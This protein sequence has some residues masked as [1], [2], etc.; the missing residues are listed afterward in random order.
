MKTLNVPLPKIS[1]STISS[2]NSHSKPA[3]VDI[4]SVKNTDASIKSKSWIFIKPE[5]PK[6]SIIN[7]QIIPPPPKGPAPSLLI[8]NGQVIPPPPNGPAPRPPLLLVNGQVIPPPPSEP[9]PLLE[10]SFGFNGDI[11]P[12]SEP[13]Q[14]ALNPDKV[15]YNPLFDNK[16]KNILVKELK[17]EHNWKKVRFYDN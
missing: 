12:S 9:A 16:A 10:A 3:S 2:R 1:L 4:I 5:N 8:V 6:V 14:L 7:G 17:T 11:L 15:T 13:L